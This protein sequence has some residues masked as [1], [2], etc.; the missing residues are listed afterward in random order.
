MDWN[1]INSIRTEIEK[2]GMYIVPGFK[3]F[4]WPGKGI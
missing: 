2:Q 3:Y 4:Y 1:N